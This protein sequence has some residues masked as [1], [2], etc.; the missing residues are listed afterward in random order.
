[1]STQE[2][3]AGFGCERCGETRHIKYL[4]SLRGKAMYKCD[5]CKFIFSR[6]LEDAE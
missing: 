1:M 3:C 2:Q 6:K 5:E 4:G